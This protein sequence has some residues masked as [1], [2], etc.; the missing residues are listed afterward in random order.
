MS[1]WKSIGQWF[2]SVPKRYWWVIAT[3]VIMQLS[4]FAALPFLYAMDVPRL[5]FTAI[6]TVASFC[7]ALIVILLLLHKD[8]ARKNLSPTRAPMGQS[9]LWAIGG[10]FMAFAVQMAAGVIEQQLFGVEHA[11]ANTQQITDISKSMPIFILVV[12]IVGPI[13]EEIVFRKV[14]FGTL[15]KK[16]NFFTAALAS[17]LIFGLVHMEISFLLT[18]AAIGFLFAFLYWMTQRIFVSIVA[19]ASMNTFVV[20]MYVLLGDRLQDILDQ[21]EKQQALIWSFFR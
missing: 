11:S 21:Y 19:H 17:S 1:V 13:L 5:Q 9:I 10:I 20:V 3:Y 6:W 12:A 14:I 15:N 18:Y 4:P 16:F 2:V 7:L 8:M